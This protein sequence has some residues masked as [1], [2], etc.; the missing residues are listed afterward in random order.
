MD[1]NKFE[2]Q[3]F[4]TTVRITIP[5]D[6]LRT[7][8]VGTGFLVNVPLRKEGL[9]GVFLV[10]NKHVYG[11]SRRT[12]VLNF[13]KKRTDVDS[14][15]LGSTAPAVIADFSA[16]YYEHPNPDIDLACINVSAFTGEENGVYSRNLHDEF[17]NHTDYSRILPGADISFIGYP[18]NRFDAIHNL[19]I[20]RKGY[21]AIN[22]CTNIRSAYYFP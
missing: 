7:S 8:S 4:F 2:N 21:L 22:S 16:H 11:D 10:S 18:D 6:D 17:F 20:L 14:P 9:T 15:D 5:N 3:V 19:P 12:I 1:L 13:H